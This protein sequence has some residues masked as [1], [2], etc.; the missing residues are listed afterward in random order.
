[1]NTLAHARCL[2]A[3]L[4][5]ALAGQSASAQDSGT[6]HAL[7]IS[8]LPATPVHADRFADWSA[9]A[10]T[11]LAGKAGVPMD[12]T[13]VLGKGATRQD[14]LNRL[15]KLAETVRHDDQFVLMIFAHGDINDSGEPKY[16]LTGPDLSAAELAEALNAIAS[17][18]Q[19][20]IDCT[21]ASGDALEKLS[22]TNRV[23]IAAT[24]PGENQTSVFGEFFLRGLE[25]G[26]ADGEAAPNAG[27]R[28]GHIT[29][30]EAYNHAA[31]EN[32]R[33]IRRIWA[34]SPPEGAA[35]PADPTEYTPRQWRV[36]GRQS[37][38]IFRKL[39]EAPEG[40]PGRKP[41]APGSKANVPDP[42]IPLTT[43]SGED[44][45]PGQF[46]N[47]RQ[48]TEHA[49]LED[50]GQGVAIAAVRGGEYQPLAGKADGEPGARARR[51]ILGKPDLLPPADNDQASNHKQ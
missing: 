41:L 2:L 4:A 26:D 1:M 15:G 32:A 14:V 28:D 11:Y 51:V 40:T 7:I 13:A 17:T 23:V 22:A 12:N 37:V 24:S 5:L 21:G 18:N 38:A 8:G 29:L 31:I 36:E 9:R 10:R 49:T 27:A 46:H 42:D 25:S 30:L 19:V 35:P 34:Y 16:A 47:I 6:T 20:V 45:T 43:P 39:Y 33:W 50:A 48:L 44:G 3:A